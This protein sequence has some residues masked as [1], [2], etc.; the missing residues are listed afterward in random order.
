[1]P[2]RSPP[3]ASAKTWSPP[4]NSTKFKSLRDVATEGNESGKL[5]SRFYAGKSR[6][7]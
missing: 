6:M 1:M 3:V 7:G 5:Q 2:V 4:V